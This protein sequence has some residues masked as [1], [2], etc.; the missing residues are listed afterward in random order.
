M[1]TIH[2][3][4]EKFNK[5]TI[6]ICYIIFV[7]ILSYLNGFPNRKITNGSVMCSV[8]SCVQKIV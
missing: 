5:N 7:H 4:F 6:F 3:H 1:D 2:V 8:V